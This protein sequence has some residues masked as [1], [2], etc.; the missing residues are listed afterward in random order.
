MTN[1]ILIIRV[2][3]ILSNQ[4]MG[5]LRES[6]SEQMKTGIIFLPI[7]CEPIIVPEGT[8]IKLENFETDA[9]K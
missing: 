9:K 6:I 8:K 4:D 7:Y 2:N 5:V 1:D 3:A